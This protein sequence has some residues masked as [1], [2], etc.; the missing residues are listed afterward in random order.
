MSR[1]RALT[2]E[3]RRAFPTGYVGQKARRFVSEQDGCIGYGATEAESRHRL[4]CELNY[5]TR[6][7]EDRT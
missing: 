5:I 4:R 3:E 1:T 7:K 6:P 2:P